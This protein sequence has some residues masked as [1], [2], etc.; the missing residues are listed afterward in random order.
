[1]G[2]YNFEFPS[3]TPVPEQIEEDAAEWDSD[4]DHGC[5]EQEAHDMFFSCADWETQIKHKTPVCEDFSDYEL[6]EA[7]PF[8][9]KRNSKMISKFGCTPEPAIKISAFDVDLVMDS[10]VCHQTEKI[11][12]AKGYFNGKRCH[13]FIAG[14][15]L[16]L[17]ISTS[18]KESA[19][20]ASSKAP[21][22]DLCLSPMGQH[23]RVPNLFESKV[24]SI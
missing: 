24:S 13:N 8:V 5:H 9:N 20:E 17:K 15:K 16:D 14:L 12:P 3:G 10:A 6:E 19:T 11:V 23:S 18:D 1:M 21:F 22:Q 2:Q 4:S 7:T